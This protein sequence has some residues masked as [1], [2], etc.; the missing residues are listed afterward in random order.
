MIAMQEGS[1]GMPYPN[2]L[3]LIESQK[4]YKKVSE[5]YK[6]IYNIAFT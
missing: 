6:E 2:M 1:Y 4:S 5:K 3:W